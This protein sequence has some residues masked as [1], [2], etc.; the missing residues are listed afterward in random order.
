MAGHAEAARG[1]E[2]ASGLHRPVA[3]L[4]AGDLALGILRLERPIGPRRGVAHRLELGQRRIAVSEREPGGIDHGAQAAV[5]VVAL[6]EV[7][8]PPTYSADWFGRPRLS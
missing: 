2:V 8:A 3:G 1:R 7:L 6:R 4:A 5:A